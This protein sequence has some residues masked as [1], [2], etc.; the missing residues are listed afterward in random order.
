MTAVDIRNCSPK[1]GKNVSPIEALTDTKPDVAHFRVCGCP[2]YA[3]VADV[4]RKKLDKK[5]RKG[6]ILRSLS[7]GKY[8]IWLENELRVDITRHC[9]IIEA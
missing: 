1:S 6:I 3:R 9:K 2:V 4:K 7:H 8:R 5:S